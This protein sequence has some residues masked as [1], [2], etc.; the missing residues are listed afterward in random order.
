M[1]F[2]TNTA[3]FFGLKISYTR[4]K[5]CKKN[6]IPI[7]TKQ[8]R[9][10]VIHRW[11]LYS[12]K[13]GRLSFSSYKNAPVTISVGSVCFKFIAFWYV[14]SKLTIELFYNSCFKVTGE[15]LQC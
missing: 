15:W 7:L 8:I 9:V 13:Y 10:R 5:K 3:V 14:A 11:V 12:N 1:L 4:P 6:F 2:V